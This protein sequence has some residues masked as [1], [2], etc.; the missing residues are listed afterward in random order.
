MTI[1]ETKDSSQ[2]S[3]E[4]NS[5]SNSELSDFLDDFF[6]ITMRDSIKR[7][8]FPLSEEGLCYLQKV[9]IRFLDA[10]NLFQEYDFHGEKR[11]G[12]K[13]ITFQHFEALE[14][15]GPAREAALQN[16][17]EECLFLVGYGYDFLRQQGLGQVRYHSDVGRAAYA[18]LSRVELSSFE[19]IVFPEVAEHFDWY[20]VVTGDLHVPALRRDNIQLKKVLDRWLE[21]RD[22]RYELLIE[23]ALGEKLVIVQNDNSR[24]N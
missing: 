4:S 7:H 12:L 8:N 6:N 10:G 11:Y 14:Q 19:P 9:A 2:F 22:R 20:S 16:L 24:K 21:T 5:K 17:A 23:G 15:K 1:D 3:S 18:G 13:P